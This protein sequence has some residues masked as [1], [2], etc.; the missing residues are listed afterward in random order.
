MTNFPSL[1]TTGGVGS[2]DAGLSTLKQKSY[3]LPVMSLGKSRDIH[4]LC[5][6]W[7]GNWASSGLR[8]AFNSATWAVAPEAG[9]RED[10][11]M[12]GA[13]EGKLVGSGR[14]LGAELQLRGGAAPPG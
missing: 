6:L 12:A 2:R 4:K 5:L 13:G 9:G 1:P 14:L 8:G 7:K 10:L 11:G 3:R